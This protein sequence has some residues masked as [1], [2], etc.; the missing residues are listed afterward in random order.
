MLRIDPTSAEMDQNT[1]YILGHLKWTTTKGPHL[2]PTGT[3]QEDIMIDITV[4]HSQDLQDCGLR[5]FQ[6]QEIIGTT[7]ACQPDIQDRPPLRVQELLLAEVLPQPRL[8][9]FAY[10]NSYYSTLRVAI[11]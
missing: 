2:D 3:L 6:Y 5:V 4:P 9:N 11:H 8:V 1:Q 7:V 10:T